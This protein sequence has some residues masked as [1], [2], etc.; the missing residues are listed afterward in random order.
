MGYYNEGVSGWWGLIG[1]LFVAGFA[2]T[3]VA[4]LGAG[5]IKLMTRPD[6]QPDAEPDR[7]AYDREGQRL[8]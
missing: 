4:V 8:A 3:V 7:P 1:V 2:L 5:V 6:M